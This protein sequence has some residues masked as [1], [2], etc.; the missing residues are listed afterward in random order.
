MNIFYFFSDHSEQT[1]RLRTGSWWNDLPDTDGHRWRR[2]GFK[3]HRTHHRGAVCESFTLPLT[4]QS[5]AKR[6]GRVCL[7]LFTCKIE[8][9]TANE[10]QVRAVQIAD[11]GT[12]ASLKV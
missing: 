1:S 3:Q 2:S 9:F 4:C 11:G 10:F 7:D 8:A 5:A 12:R 6:K